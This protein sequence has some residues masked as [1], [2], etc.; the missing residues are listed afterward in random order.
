MIGPSFQAVLR[1]AKRGDEQAFGVLYRDLQPRV[2]RYLRVLAAGA[3]EDLA[4]DTWLQVVRRLGCFRGEELAFRAWVCLIA[5]HRAIDWRRQAARRQ[6]EPV[7]PD[8]LPTQLAPDD[9]AATAL[10]GFS[11]QAAIALLSTL[12]ADQAE[13]IMLRVV[14]GLDVNRVAQ[15]MGKHPTT[16]RVLAHRGLRRLAARL[17][18]DARIGGML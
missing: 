2:L 17:G 10:E 6:T 12:P 5:R 18:A 3:A 15:L 8:A 14:A 1:N 4:A 13:V 9:P 16:V 11:T 7:A